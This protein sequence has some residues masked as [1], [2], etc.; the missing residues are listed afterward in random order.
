MTF[1]GSFSAVGVFGQLIRIVPELDLVIV[2]NSGTEQSTDVDGIVDQFAHAAPP[3]CG[4]MKAAN[5]RRTV[6]VG[7][8]V[9]IRVLANDHS[10][11]GR[12]DLSRLSLV[13]L[14]ARGEAHVTGRTVV[15]RVP[16]GAPKGTQ[17]FS[18]EICN[19]RRDCDEAQVTIHIS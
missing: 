1:P 2:V 18:Y 3:G 4:T 10:S 15:Y 19:R 9:A 11:G 5:D 17:T 7:H 14:P 16:A 6:R 8:A 12:V 13:D